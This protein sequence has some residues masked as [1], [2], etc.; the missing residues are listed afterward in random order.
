MKYVVLHPITERGLTQVL[1]C[2]APTTHAQLA[3]AHAATHAPVSA[4]YIDVARGPDG[5]PAVRTFGRS[6]SLGLEPRAQDARLIGQMMRAT[7][8]TAPDA[9]S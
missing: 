2:V 8:A 9:L 5:G 4:G 1:F 6:D 3:A 7:L